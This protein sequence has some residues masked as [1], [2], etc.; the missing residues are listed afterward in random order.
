MRAEVLN[1]RER[2]R[3]WSDK[4]KNRIVEETLTSGLTIADVARRNDVAV[5]LVHTWRRRAREC[6]LGAPSSTRLI[7]VKVFSAPSDAG[8][9]P[10]AQPTCD[11]HTESTG[12]GCGAGSIEI[13]LGDGRRIRVDA[14]FNA[15]TLARVLSVLERR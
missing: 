5:S 15:S 1:G 11:K 8:N 2:R 3:M 12:N 14:H 6:T 7:P 4:D 9:H 13:D 10:A